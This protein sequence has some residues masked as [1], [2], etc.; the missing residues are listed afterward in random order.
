MTTVDSRLKPAAVAGT[1]YPADPGVLDATVRRMLADASGPALQPKAIAAPHAG[2][3]FSGPVAASAFR[4]IAGR[5]ATVRRVVLIGPSHFLA[6]QGLAL[7]SADGFATP[8]GVVPVDREAQAALLG[9]PG[10]AVNDAAFAREHGIEV[11]LPFLQTVL[12]D[13][14]IV[15]IVVGGAD[16]RLVAE[17]LRRLW[18]GPETLILI[19]TDLSHFHP[20]AAAQGL[21]AACAK[22]VEL[23]DPAA[24]TDQQA[25]GRLP[26][27][28]LLHLARHHDLRPTTVD[29]RNSGDTRGGR[30]RVVGYGAFAFEYAH[31]ARLGPEERRRLVDAAKW[32]VRFGLEKGRPP[33]MSIAPGTHGPLTAHRAAFVTITLD[34]ALRGCIGSVVAHQP[35]I[36]DV[37][38][39]AYKAAFG[40]PRFRPLTAAEAERIEVSVSVL[41]TPRPIAAAGEDALVAALRPDVD[42]LII[43]DGGKRSIF[44]PSVWSGIPDPRAFLH[45][46]QRKAGLRPGHWSDGFRA[47]RFST[48]SFDDG[49]AGADAA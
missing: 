22:S 43:Q 15:P 25:C 8:L 18:G 42:G 14:A 17:A 20:Y 24:I 35:L 33:R 21:D 4:L 11:E 40:D 26:L 46:L 39:N 44:L 47:S 1:F 2:Y 16:E 30:D 6:F 3:A 19:S 38:G 9:M 5:A 32:G 28:G 31:S 29:L 13:F 45:Q 49:R 36:V 27:K 10:V 41:S 7:S 23:L 48:E 34:G 37:A 12:D